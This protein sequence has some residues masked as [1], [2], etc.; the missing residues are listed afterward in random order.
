M[1]SPD[2]YSCSRL[3]S[4]PLF[5]T[6]YLSS[7]FCATFNRYPHSNFPSFIFIQPNKMSIKFN[8]FPYLVKLAVMN[9]MNYMSI[10]MLSLC[11]I[12]TKKF[13]EKHLRK[14]LTSIKYFFSTNG[15]QVLVEN[16]DGSGELM[17]GVHACY[18]TL[19]LCH[20]SNTRI[21]NVQRLVGNKNSFVD[22]MSFDCRE[23][24]Q[25]ERES[26]RKMAAFRFF[27][28]TFVLLIWNRTRDQFVE[29]VR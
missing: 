5:C 7:V 6:F 14:D 12:R 2:L 25:I 9:Q 11:S 22:P 24:Y 20:L 4:F 28:H 21:G 10:F 1:M 27:R 18:D 3:T 15:I 16:P 29:V 8:S 17:V 23:F 19:H 13:I 26:D